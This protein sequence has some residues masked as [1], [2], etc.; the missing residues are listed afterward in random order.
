MIRKEVD[1]KIPFEKKTRQVTAERRGLREWRKTNEKKITEKQRRR[2]ALL[3][4]RVIVARKYVMKRIAR[5]EQTANIKRRPRKR[6]KKMPSKEE[7][8][9]TRDE[10][11]PPLQ[12]IVVRI[13]IA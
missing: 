9:E 3:E 4:T 5:D 11:T 7:N 1:K 13:D 10:P 12:P 6:S 8:Y 2:R